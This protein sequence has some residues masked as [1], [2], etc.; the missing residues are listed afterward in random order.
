M[1]LIH[2]EGLEL[3]CIVGLRSH[4]RHR[5][6]PLRADIWLGLDLSEAGRSGRIG[7]TADYAK[8]ADAVASLLRFREYRLL[9]VAAEES[10]AFLFAGYPFIKSVRLRLQKPEA[11]A[12]RARA[13]AVE[14]ER[15]RGAFVAVEAV[16]PFGSR[17]E[18]LR[19]GEA[20]IEL[21]WIQPGGE[22]EL[23]EPLPHLDWVPGDASNEARAPV[24]REAGESFQIQ[25][26][27]VDGLRVAR[28]LKHEAVRSGS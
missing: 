27:A 25:V 19:T 17:T 16:T 22:V 26:K 28:C 15:T 5:E 10:A 24:A 9:E 21:L 12:G 23:T 11:L 18:L 13:A 20:T 4:E 6:Q 3:R 1:D 7:D 14:I 2:I 8:V